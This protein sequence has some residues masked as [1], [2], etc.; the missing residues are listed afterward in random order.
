MNWENISILIDIGLR[1]IKFFLIFKH[2]FHE[3]L[4]NNLFLTLNITNETGTNYI[5]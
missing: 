2:F 1:Y 3:K 4:K 5:D